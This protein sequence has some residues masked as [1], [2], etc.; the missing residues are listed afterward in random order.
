MDSPDDFGDSN[1][2]TSNLSSHHIECIGNLNW[3]GKKKR[4]KSRNPSKGGI[5]TVLV[6]SQM[7]HQSILRHVFLIL[8]LTIS[9]HSIF[10]TVHMIIHFNLLGRRNFLKAKKMQVRSN[11]MTIWPTHI[12]LTNVETWRKKIVGQA[13]WTPSDW[14]RQTIPY[15]KNVKKGQPARNMP[16]YSFVGSWC[17]LPPYLA[18]IGMVAFSTP[19]IQQ[20]NQAFAMRWDVL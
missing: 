15:R 11:G 9:R 19:V 4:K 12:V 2:G 8:T 13:F 20:T 6:Q 7:F 1:P 3:K 14:K 5:S 10:K 18:I 17:C 16:T